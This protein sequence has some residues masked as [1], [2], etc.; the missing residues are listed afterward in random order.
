MKITDAD[1]NEIIYV[2]ALNKFLYSEM[3]L[4]KSVNID[5]RVMDRYERKLKSTNNFRC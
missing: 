4:R 3:L 5:F 1:F 2:T